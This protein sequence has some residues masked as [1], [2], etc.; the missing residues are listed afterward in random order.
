MAEIFPD[1]GLDLMLGIFPKN[2]SNLANTYLMLFTGA[3]ASTTPSANSVLATNG[4][5]TPPAEASYTS[6][7][8]VAHAAG[9]WGS[10]GADTIWSQTVRRVLGTQTSFPAAGAA[11]STPI[12]GFGLA[13]QLATGAGS[14]G[15]FY[16]NFDDSTAI[17]SLALNDV[18]K[19]T[20]KFGLGG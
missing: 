3:T 12:N 11:Y 5:T 15:I 4:G 14:I 9:S 8:R 6:Y 7:A 18:V 16:S 20:P 2:G 1:E 17:A 19:V 10:A 13:N